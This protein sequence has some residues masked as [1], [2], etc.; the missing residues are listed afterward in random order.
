MFFKKL[1]NGKYRYYEKFLD[2]TLKKWRQVSVT[3]NSKSRVSQS[4]AKLRLVE[5]INSA[6]TK[7]R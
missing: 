6:Q 2:E 4:E 3:M 1:E 5:K 7:K